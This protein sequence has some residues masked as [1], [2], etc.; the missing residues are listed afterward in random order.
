MRQGIVIG[1]VGLGLCIMTWVI[2]YCKYFTCQT[3]PCL[4]QPGA[5]QQSNKNSK[6]MRQCT[7]LL[8]VFGGVAWH[9]RACTT[10]TLIHEE[11]WWQMPHTGP[12]SLGEIGGHLHVGWQQP[13]WGQHYRVTFKNAHGHKH[14]RP[15]MKPSLKCSSTF[16][17]R[18]N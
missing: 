10:D 3:S 6:K 2:K 18:I 5:P 17:D 14:K 7:P 13:F 16:E 12:P 8:F 4:T 15:N 9:T 11:H 1:V